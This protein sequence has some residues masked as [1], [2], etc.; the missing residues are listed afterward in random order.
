MLE[1]QEGDYIIDKS[2]PWH[3]EGVVTNVEYMPGGHISSI[4]YDCYIRERLHFGFVYVGYKFNPDT[5]EK[6]Q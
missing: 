5:V 4:A 2:S 1:I 3:N 6:I